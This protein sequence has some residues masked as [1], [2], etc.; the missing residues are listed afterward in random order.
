M[1]INKE[2]LKR[3]DMSMRAKGLLAYLLSLPDDWQI[4]RKELTSHFTNGLESIS[5]ALQ[6]LVNTG[7]I[8][9]FQIRDDSQRFSEMIY[10]VFETPHLQIESP[11]KA[12]RE[13]ESRD[14]E[15]RV[16]ESRS[17]IK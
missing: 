1:T 9:R 6:E 4:K 7:Y 2:F 5:S 13:A 17:L 14:R 11:Q 16:T 15:N 8:V 10:D 12:F 3:P